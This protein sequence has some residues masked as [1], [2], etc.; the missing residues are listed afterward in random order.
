MP[1]D[2]DIL[3][4]QGL[5]QYQRISKHSIFTSEWSTLPPFLSTHVHHCS[6]SLMTST[7]PARHGYPFLLLGIRTTARSRKSFLRAN[8]AA[9]SIMIVAQPACSPLKTS[10]TEA[11]P[12]EI[13]S[14]M[15]QVWKHRKKKSKADQSQWRQCA[16]RLHA[17]GFHAGSPREP[18]YWQRMQR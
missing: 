17:R 5:H 15:A 13:L 18:S 7:Q 4:L 11:T 6:P 3:H 8:H 9:W 1:T 2:I 14:P 10:S 12:T 16:S